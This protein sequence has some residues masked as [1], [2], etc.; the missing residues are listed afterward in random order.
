MYLVMLGCRAPL[1]NTIQG[2]LQVTWYQLGPPPRPE[3][4]ETKVSMW[5]VNHVYSTESQ[6]K[7]QHQG[8][9]ERPWLDTP[10]CIAAESR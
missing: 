7:L 3:E 2:G 4:L 6:Q 5:V 9:G 8:S 10:M 1:N